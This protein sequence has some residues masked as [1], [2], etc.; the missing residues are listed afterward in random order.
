MRPTTSRLTELV[1]LTGRYDF[2]YSGTLQL[3]GHLALRSHSTRAQHAF[4]STCASNKGA[5]LSSSASVLSPVNSVHHRVF[6]SR[7]HFS[8]QSDDQDGTVASETPGTA[9]MQERQPATSATSEA[10]IDEFT[11][12]APVTDSFAVFSGEGPDGAQMMGQDIGDLPIMQGPGVMAPPKPELVAKYLSP[13]HFNAAEAYKWQKHELIRELQSFE[14]DTGSMPVRIGLLTQ[15]IKYLTRHTQTHRKDHHSRRGLLILLSRRRKS[16]R[17]LRRKDFDAYV[18]ILKRFGLKDN[19][20]QSGW[21]ERYRVGTN[22]KWSPDQTDKEKLPPP[23]QLRAEVMAEQR[24]RRRKT[25]RAH[26]S[27]RFTMEDADRNVIWKA[28]PDPEGPGSGVF[29]P[30]TVKTHE[31]NK[32]KIRQRA[33]HMTQ[34]WQQRLQGVQH[35]YPAEL[36]QPGHE[37]QRLQAAAQRGELATAEVERMRE[38]RAAQKEA[39]RA[40]RSA[41][42]MEVEGAV[43]PRYRAGPAAQRRASAAL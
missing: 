40:R 34:T 18:K 20:Y 8:S 2:G 5:C 22:L 9:S 6:A 31:Y 10:G 35:F 16:L 37:Q 23:E 39:R 30:R 26:R 24:Q 32:E 28:G 43:L 41:R 29:T 21:G 27:V 25:V 4:N 36:E 14:H 42:K 11:F 33:V 38:I 7:R 15:R 1:R 12:P 3:S 17:V 19:Y 13:D